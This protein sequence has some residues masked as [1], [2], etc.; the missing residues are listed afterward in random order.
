MLGDGFMMTSPDQLLLTHTVRLKLPDVDTL[1]AFE[2]L[3]FCEGSI[4]FQLASPVCLDGIHLL[5]SL[6][7]E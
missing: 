4:I 2:S 6:L 5:D 7:A 1:I 3:S